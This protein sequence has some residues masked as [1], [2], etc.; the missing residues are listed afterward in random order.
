[1]RAVGAP[2]VSE[3]SFARLSCHGRPALSLLDFGFPLLEVRF[4]LRSLPQSDLRAV[5]HNAARQI[6]SLLTRE[7]LN[8]RHAKSL[9]DVRAAD[10]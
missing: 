2:E 9:T 10:V 7:Q 6:S 4:D 8:A 3:P 5:D 1:M